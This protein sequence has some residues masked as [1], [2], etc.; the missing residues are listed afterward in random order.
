LRGR[1]AIFAIQCRVYFVALCLQP[2]SLAQVLANPV[3]HRFKLARDKQVGREA[4][5]DH[6]VIGKKTGN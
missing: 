1:S 4:F 2:A 3:R 5:M 6:A